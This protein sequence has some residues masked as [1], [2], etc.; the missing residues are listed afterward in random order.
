MNY[1]ILKL[2]GDA[3]L[4]DQQAQAAQNAIY[5][6][7]GMAGGL[8]ALIAGIGGYMANK[9]SKQA[10]EART[11]AQNKLGIM[12]QSFAEY[13]AEQAAK[14]A[15]LARQQKLEDDAAKRAHELAEIE[16]QN[17]GRMSI[18]Q[19]KV[20]NRAP[21]QMSHQERM[22]QMMSPEQRESYMNQYAGIEQAGGTVFSPEIQ[23]GVNSGAITQQE[24]VNR[25]RDKS[26]GVKPE[27]QAEIK[28]EAARVNV[29][30]GV[31]ELKN[32]V[33]EHGTEYFGGN[34][35]KMSA[36]RTQLVLD[37]KEA[38]ELGALTG[39]DLQLV[40]QLIGDPTSIGSN[41]N[42]FNGDDNIMAQLE[43]LESRYGQQPKNPQQGQSSDQELY[44]KY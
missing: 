12:N 38:A 8:G 39:P 6:Q 17:A 33:Q 22:W 11:E 40:D 9:R 29:M 24:A 35:K 41:L 19:F 10:N 37:L 31:N 5:S 42:I 16:A 4:Y 13:E 43:Y 36:A 21:E 2:M 20:A 14:A 25:Q 34:A 32:L 15:E 27:S 23:A 7:N 28:K 1:E 3:E 26:L 30:K 18:E 44:N